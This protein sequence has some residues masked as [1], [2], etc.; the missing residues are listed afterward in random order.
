MKSHYDK[1]TELIIVIIFNFCVSHLCTI[2]GWNNGFDRGRYCEAAGRAE[3]ILW[4]VA[5]KKVRA[6]TELARV[7]VLASIL[8]NEMGQTK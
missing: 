6:Q 2:M 3:A 4:W 5:G 8:T 1:L 7:I